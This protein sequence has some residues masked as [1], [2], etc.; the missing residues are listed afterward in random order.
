MTVNLFWCIIKKIRIYSLTL[1]ENKNFPFT[2]FHLEK[3]KIM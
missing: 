1:F 3:K 2:S